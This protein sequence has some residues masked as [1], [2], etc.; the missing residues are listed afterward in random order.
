MAKGHHSVSQE[1]ISSANIP[2]GKAEQQTPDCRAAPNVQNA[3]V[4]RVKQIDRTIAVV[5]DP[6]SLAEKR[7]SVLGH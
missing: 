7:V 6:H 4:K 3:P 2:I 5:A 1:L